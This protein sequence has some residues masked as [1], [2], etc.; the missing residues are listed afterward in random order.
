MSIDLRGTREKTGMSQA[1]LAAMLELSEEE[2]NL[3]EQ[4]L[5]TV[6]FELLLRWTQ[7]LGT[8]LATLTTSAIPLSSSV[9]A[10]DPY[11]QLQRDLM[12][13]E[14]YITDFSVAG[15]LNIPEPPLTPEDII[16]QINRYRQKPNLVLVGRFDSGKSHLANTLMGEKVLPSQYQPA[17]RVI[18]FV[19]HISDRPVWFL[20]QVGILA[21][22]F[23]PKDEKD[24]QVFD[25]TLLDAQH[26]FDRHCI[27]A[28]SLDVLRQHGVH[29]HL[30]EREIE[31]HS[32]IVYVDSPLLKACNLVDFPGYSDQAD[33]ISEDVKKA[34]SAIQIADLI[35]Y[36]S[37][38]NGFM[39]AE[40]F[41]RL[42]YFLKVLPS[43]ETL[44]PDFPI[45]RNFF[46]VGTHAHPGISGSQVSEALQIG[47]VRLYNHLKETVIE[48]RGKLINQ[49]IKLE[50]LQRHFFA[51]WEETPRRWENLKKEL[52]AVLG[53]SLPK[54]RRKRIDYEINLLKS[55]VLKKIAENLQAYEQTGSES[56]QRQLEIE[57]LEKEEPHRHKR[58]EQG[59][60][61]IDQ[62]IKEL[63]DKTKKSFEQT[64]NNMVN[65][66][67]VET[68]IRNRYK[69]NKKEA[70][71]YAGGYLVEQ[72]QGKLEAYIKENAE[73]LK[74]DID[75]FLNIYEEVLLKFPK[76]N[77]GSV[78]IPFNAKGAFLGGIA[79]AG[80]VG[81]LAFWAASLGNLGAYI[82]VAKFV[83]LLSFLGISISGG[84]ATVVS[85]VA[86]IGGP[87]TLGIGL[88]AAVAALGWKLFGESWERRL[89]KEI[90]NN[91]EKQQALN[92]FVE[93]SNDY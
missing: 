14:Q 50:H 81:A 1:E 22:D 36:T 41:S 59:C 79:G 55:E 29:D 4:N 75:Q 3:Y 21:E 18:T 65:V 80:G 68:M 13:L 25:L 40:D 43:P 84:V 83:S 74:V 2:V 85:F 69:D 11:L 37:P 63:E 86:A 15:E 24:N 53:Q 8:D 51:F 16:K 76:L 26:W 67:A 78:S 70:R 38:I 52:I 66:S 7:A 17:T 54:A 71:E 93:A 27:K 19:R 33:Q 47:S 49:S 57:E 88:F 64:Y 35:L 10:G 48:E 23:W 31:G 58:I 46:I 20:E 32:A 91:F 34:N 72:L 9:D 82:L 30:N 12:L 92:K 62:R 90:V 61:Q 44:D 5:G 28:G 39:N 87:L 45:L 56:G 42:S 77:I 89:A 60:Y 73:A 6:P